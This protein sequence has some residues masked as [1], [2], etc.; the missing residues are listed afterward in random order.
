MRILQVSGVFCDEAGGGVGDYVCSLG[1][2]LVK[3]GH[4]VEVLTYSRH[5][6][7]R[8]HTGQIVH[9]VPLSRITGVRYF[10]WGRDANRFLT[11][12]L[13]STDFDLVH[14]HTTSM[15]FPLYYR[16]TRPLVITCH[17]TST[18]PVHGFARSLVLSRIERRYYNRA[19]RV[20]AVSHAV[21]RELL[22]KGVPENVIHVIPNGTDESRFRRVRRD[23]QAARSQ[24]GIEPNQIVALFVGA[25]TERKGFR[26]L[27]Q[28][29]DEI[30]RR[31]KA[32][33]R[34]LLVGS[35][36][37]SSAARRLAKRRPEVA[38]LGF[39][40]EPV[41]ELA[42]VASDVFVFPSFYEGLPTAVLDA[43]GF[44]LPVVASDIPALRETLSESCAFFVRPND[45]DSLASAFERIASNRSQLIQ[46][47]V[48]ASLESKR[49]SWEPIANQI[50]ELYRV[51]L[52]ESN[53]DSS[54]RSRN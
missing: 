13:Q 52:S 23:K 32:S 34:F 54:P 42:Y 39:V 1:N 3:Q 38:N 37:L 46:M 5:D 18:D 8:E 14:A 22:A 51:V 47:G 16:S 27:L 48:S 10:Q 40:S 44:G 50:A 31:K 4:E 12:L 49:F 11:G 20:V 30:L 24:L 28:A 29:A 6:S 35:G 9:F 7:K 2:N 19:S 43:L 41:L 33:Y 17:G 26:V 21:R 36:P 15:S 25:H 53:L 45:A